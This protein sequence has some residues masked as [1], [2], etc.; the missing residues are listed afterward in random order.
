MTPMNRSL[1]GGLL[2]VLA[3]SDYAVAADAKESLPQGAQLVALEVHPKAIDLKHHFDYAQLLVTAKLA[4]G[5]QI[6]ATRMVA[7]QAPDKV[8]AISPR[9]IVSPTA[10]GPGNPTISLAGK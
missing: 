6:D 4:S 3:G 1:V 8:A 2:L 5:D 7:V 10:D 9:G